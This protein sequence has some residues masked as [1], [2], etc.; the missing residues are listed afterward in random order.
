[1]GSMIRSIGVYNPKWDMGDCWDYTHSLRAQ[2]EDEARDHQSA[3]KCGETG[4][5]DFEVRLKR[6]SSERSDRRVAC[7]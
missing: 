4:I 2:V 5:H 7:D 3:D 1:M 6:R